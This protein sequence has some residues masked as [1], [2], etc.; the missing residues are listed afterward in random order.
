MLP[1]YIDRFMAHDA[2]KW[3]HNNIH[4]LPD[5]A[6]YAASS[7]IRSLNWANTID[8]INLK[9]PAQYCALHATEEAVACLIHVL[10]VKEYQKS[11]NI[12]IK[13]HEDKSTISIVSQGL[14]NIFKE[15]EIQFAYS[16]TEDQII[17]KTTFNGKLKYD[18]ASLEYFSFSIENGNSMISDIN[19]YFGNFDNLAN[20][21][22]IS[23]NAR[24]KIFYADKDGYP[25][26]FDDHKK[27]LEREVNLTIA[28]IW[29][30]INIFNT[31]EKMKIVEQFLDTSTHIISTMNSKKTHYIK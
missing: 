6:S 5:R 11:D 20:Q 17:I 13:D 9:I 7:A 3:I 30:S 26:G 2:A 18:T 14:I 27:C 25:T 24:N 19:E 31:N 23:R 16:D 12:N 1:S 10:K 28:M 8:K 15:Y 4:T 22:Q 29:A 21:I